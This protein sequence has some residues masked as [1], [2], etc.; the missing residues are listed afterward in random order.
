M[1]A[2][3]AWSTSLPS[4]PT[5]AASSPVNPPLDG[6][7]LRAD[8]ASTLYAHKQLQH[9]AIHFPNPDIHMPRHVTLKTVRCMAVLHSE[10]SVPLRPLCWKMLEPTAQ[11]PKP[12][13]MW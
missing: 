4:S 11:S 12:L 13:D 9:E 3:I 8:S 6:V 1:A 5:C 2:I 7:T 10:Q